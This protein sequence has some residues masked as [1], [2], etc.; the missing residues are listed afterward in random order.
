LAQEHLRSPAH[1]YTG[2]KAGVAMLERIRQ[3]Q[4]VTRKP[5]CRRETARC[6]VLLPIHSM[7]VRVKH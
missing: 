7:T 3:Q 6:S 4:T 5:S 2:V 1:F